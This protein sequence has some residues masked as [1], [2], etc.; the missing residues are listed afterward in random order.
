MEDEISRDEL[1]RRLE[2]LRPEFAKLMRQCGAH[3]PDWTPLESVLMGDFMF[4]GYG[5]NGIR[6]YKHSI[7]RRYLNLDEA[8]RAYRFI[9]RGE[10]YEPIPLEDGIAYAFT[11]VEMLLAPY[12]GRSQDDWPR[13]HG[14]EQA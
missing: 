13:L 2:A 14:P 1:I 9:A 4:M 6:L 10:R 8:G 7:T 3:E 11:D 12:R 5:P